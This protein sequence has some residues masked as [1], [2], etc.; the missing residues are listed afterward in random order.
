M[1]SHKSWKVWR[2]TFLKNSDT[3]NGVAKIVKSVAPHFFLK[4]KYKKIGRRTFQKTPHFEIYLE[5]TRFLYFLRFSQCA[6]SHFRR[7]GLYE[8]I[9]RHTFSK[10]ST[11]ETVSQ[12]LLKVWRHTFS[13]NYDT[14]SDVAKIVKSVAPHFFENLGN[15]SKS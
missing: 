8:K 10:N 4:T 3:K 6:A 11:W 1:V 13:K 5:I 12:K 2:H 9:G 14:K 7:P 15:P